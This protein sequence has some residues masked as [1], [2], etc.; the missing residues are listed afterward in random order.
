ME[1]LSFMKFVVGEPM[2]QLPAPLKPDTVTAAM[3]LVPAMI[4][5]AGERA[6]LVLDCQRAATSP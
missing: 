1:S 3:H 4:A 6:R 2:P 5:H